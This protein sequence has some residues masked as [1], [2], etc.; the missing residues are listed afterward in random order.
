MIVSAGLLILAQTTLKLSLRGL[1][2]EDLHANLAGSIVGILRQPLFWLSIG[3]SGVIFLMTLYNLV[4]TPLSTFVPVY[5]ALYFFGL[6]AV[7]VFALHETVSLAKMLG[8]ILLAG[9]LILISRAH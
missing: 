2:L 6:L 4:T 3:L 5:L 8:Y 1:R 9:G 7:S